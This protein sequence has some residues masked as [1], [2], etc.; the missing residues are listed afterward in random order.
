[1]IFCYRNLNRL[2]QNPSLSYFKVVVADSV[3][4]VITF[5]SVSVGSTALGS[6]PLQLEQFQCYLSNT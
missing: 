5:L 4:Q 6:A 2:K 1:M 3:I